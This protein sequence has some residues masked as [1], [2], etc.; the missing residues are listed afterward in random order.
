MIAIS[1]APSFI[2]TPQVFRHTRKRR[3]RR[4]FS[5]QNSH[6]NTYIV[7]DWGTS[8]LRLYLCQGTQV[9]DRREG[10]GVAELSAT[11]QTQAHA[12]RFAVALSAAIAPWSR[13]H[14][15]MHV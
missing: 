8:H 7:G 5:H 1:I 6:M 14:G 11:A 3:R 10:P 15:S 12:R 13:T 2:A 4:L 9:L